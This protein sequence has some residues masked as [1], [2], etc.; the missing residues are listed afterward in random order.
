MKITYD[1]EV[2]AFYIR[3]TETTVTTK[4]L[5][6][7]I[8]ADYDA[9]GHLAGIEILDAKKRLG[10]P[11]AFRQVILE[12]IAVAS[13]SLLC[14]RN[15]DQGTRLCR[16]HPGSARQGVAGWRHRHGG[17][18]SRG[19]GGLRGGVHD[20][21]RRNAGCGYVAANASAPHCAAGC[22]P[23]A[24][25]CSCQLVIPCGECGSPYFPHVADVIFSGFAE[26]APRALRGRAVF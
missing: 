7:G 24:G 2:D 16:P 17:A 3:F 10:D 20:V 8:A 11:A 21:G 18:H 4:H 15:G 19:R 26:A 25:A 23:C 9:E 1:R 14:G 13:P 22:R 6:E 5:A 12:D